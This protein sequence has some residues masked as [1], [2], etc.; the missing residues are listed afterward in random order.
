MPR[1]TYIYRSLL[2]FLMGVLP[3][4][5]T[6]TAEAAQKIP[7]LL[8][9]H[10]QDLSPKASPLLRAWTLSPGK[11]DSQVGWLVGHGFHTITM[12][13]LVAHLKHRRPLPDKPIVLTFDDG[14]RDHYEVAFPILRKYKCVATFFI[15]TDGVGH[16]AY[17]NWGQIRQMALAGMDMEAHSL[18]HP[19]L[20]KIPPQ[21]AY[22]EIWQS[23]QSLESQLHR[24]VTI[25]AYPFG[26]Y[27]DSII[28]MVRHAGFEAAA[29][30]SGMNGSYIYRADET[31]TLF[32]KVVMNYE[33]LDHFAGLSR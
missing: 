9:H 28:G 5:G 8:Y 32:R 24:P 10:L 30:V 4:A 2:L 29:A 27:N 20:T 21:E 31:Y 15:I 17:M 14:W 13:Q 25:F 23:K 7:I 18:T 16:S 26:A 11:L 6:A 12:A 22:R 1:C 3:I 19:K 33:S